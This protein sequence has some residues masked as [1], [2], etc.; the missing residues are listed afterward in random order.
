[1][2]RELYDPNTPPQRIAQLT[3]I[4]PGLEAELRSAV[5]R[6][7]TGYAAK[8]GAETG[9]MLGVPANLLYQGYADQKAYKTENAP[10]FAELDKLKEGQAR[11]D[12]A[13]AKKE[14]SVKDAKPGSK[15]ADLKAKNL[16]KMRTIKAQSIN[17]LTAKETALEKKRPKLFNKPIRRAL[18]GGAAGAVLGALAGAGTKQ[19]TRDNAAY[20]N[21]LLALTEG[22]NW[23]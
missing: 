2:Q 11:I 22:G 6:E 13:L 21:A 9:A 15:A 4:V 8:E 17:N 19:F 5:R 23:V 16:D 1:M 14:T 18:T 10:A 3:S 20:E 12:A 7:G